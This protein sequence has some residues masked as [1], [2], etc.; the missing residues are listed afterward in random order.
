LDKEVYPGDY[1][2]L[3]VPEEK[4]YV[5]LRSTTS[6]KKKAFQDVLHKK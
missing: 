3:I 4:P 5:E 1:R 6:G 2:N